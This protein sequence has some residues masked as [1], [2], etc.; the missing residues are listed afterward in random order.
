MA[1][2]GADCEIS[3]PIGTLVRDSET[4]ELLAEILK[5]G[6]RAAV[7]VGGAGGRGNARFV[8]S[9]NR[10]PRYH[11]PG[12]EILP[13]KIRLELKL[14]AD[15]AIVGFP[16]AGKSTLISRISSATP[17]IEGLCVYHASPQSGCGAL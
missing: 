8:S 10:A 15:V 7:Q 16:N 13:F 3:V 17:R 4:G 9:T 11:E 1:G 6:Q 14:I 12:E 2:M 5:D